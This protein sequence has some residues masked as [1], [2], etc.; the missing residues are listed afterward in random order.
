MIDTFTKE[1]VSD[2]RRTC[3]R[4]KMLCDEA[5]EGK[6]MASQLMMLGSNITDF[7]QNPI[8]KNSGCV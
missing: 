1:N 8:V 3:D 2:L 7:V 6:L 4:I 5:V